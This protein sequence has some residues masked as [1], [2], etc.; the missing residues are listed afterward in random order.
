ML[1]NAYLLAKIGADTAE[2]ERL[3]YKTFAK[4]SCNYRTTLPRPTGSPEVVA[5]SGCA[6]GP[7]GEPRSF[8]PGGLGDDRVLAPGDA[9]QE[10]LEG[11]EPRPLERHG[12]LTVT[13]FAKSLSRI[14]LN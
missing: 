9:A 3:F 13:F 4:K 10:A 5:E 6:S 1:K 8:R 14:Q 7:G 12:P 2:N 11:V